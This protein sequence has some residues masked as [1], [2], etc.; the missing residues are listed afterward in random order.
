M[1]ILFSLGLLFAVFLL[2]FF[3]LRPI[4]RYCK[5]QQIEPNRWVIKILGG[6]VLLWIGGPPLFEFAFSLP[7]KSAWTV[8]FLLSFSMGWYLFVRNQLHQK[9]RTSAFQDEIDDIG[10]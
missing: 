3:L 5:E 10:R 9:G 7:P 2:G 1:L 4:I 6:W 8:F